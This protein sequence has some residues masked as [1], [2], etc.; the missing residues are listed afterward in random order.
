MIRQKKI[1][2][3][4]EKL[5]KAQTVEEIVDLLDEYFP[6]NF[7]K[8]Q[9]AWGYGCEFVPICWQKWVEDDPLASGLFERYDPSWEEKL[10][11]A[12]VG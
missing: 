3:G 11:V 5:Q 10:E 6:Q 4:V 8:C 7:S 12:D 9:P 1:A 2:E